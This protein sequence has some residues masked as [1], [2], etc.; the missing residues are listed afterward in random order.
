M[1]ETAIMTLMDVGPETFEPLVGQKIWLQGAAG[2]AI[3]VEVLEVRRGRLLP[4]GGPTPRREGFS[5]LFEYGAATP[6]NISGTFALRIDGFPPEPVFIS[7]I[8]PP[9]N[10]SAQGVYLEA[11]FS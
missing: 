9:V 4:T 3:E 6:D 2:F 11:C 8:V 10:R 5:V 7:R 1:Q